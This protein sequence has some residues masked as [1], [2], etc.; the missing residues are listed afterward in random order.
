MVPTG[1][2]GPGSEAMSGPDVSGSVGRYTE[3]ITVRLAMPGT[4]SGDPADAGPASISDR[5]MADLLFEGLTRLDSSGQ[6]VVG[7][8]E[9]WEV[10]ADRLDWTFV[11][12]SGLT[13]GQGDRIT[14]SDVAASLDRVAGRGP[15]DQ[16]ATALTAVT[17]WDARMA[18]KAGSVSGIVVID[19]TTLELRLDHPFE[20]LPAVL[21][22]PAFG[23]V[24]LRPDGTTGTT[25]AFRPTDDPSRLEAVSDSSAVAAVDLVPIQGDVAPLVEN[26]AVDWAVIPPGQAVADPPGDVL[27][28]P[29]DM[30]VG[31]AVRLAARSKRVGLG[32]LIDPVAVSAEVP[33]LS[34]LVSIPVDGPASPPSAVVIDAPEGRLADVSKAAAA[35]LEA[36]GVNVDL[37]VSSPSEF[38]ARVISGEATVF[39]VLIAGGT[40][41]GGSTLRFF[42]PGGVDDVAGTVS[43]R[44]SAL[45]EQAMA[46]LD[47]A[48]RADTLAT[49]E[50]L[51][52][53]AGLVKVVG[54][55]EV[56]VSIGS[57]LSGLRQRADGTLDLA[58]VTL[59]AR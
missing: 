28:V 20:Q 21:A 34:A 23:V 22:S 12:P 55:W 40:G 42:A 30:R 38:A 41:A 54:Q 8:A 3:P 10:S 29:L 1:T 47:P 53:D 4:W 17:G 32:E 58:R 46:E 57:R 9:R 43:G 11:L 13:D 52:I 45:A 44:G 26:G 24:V 16:A 50:R 19:D 18:G 15:A 14:A 5:V 31:F 49:L 51:V 59:A 7:L 36:A 6:P 2:P 35:L 56:T 33:G 25:G 27:R 39:P 48:A 37:R